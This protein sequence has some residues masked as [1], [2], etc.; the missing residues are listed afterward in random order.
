MRGHYP[1]TCHRFQSAQH[2]T[3]T[4]ELSCREPTLNGNPVGVVCK[5]VSKQRDRIQYCSGRIPIHGI[6]MGPLQQPEVDEERSERNRHQV[7]SGAKRTMSADCMIP[8]LIRRCLPPT[9]NSG[10]PDGL[11]TSFGSQCLNG[12][13]LGVSDHFFFPLPHVPASSRSVAMILLIFSVLFMPGTMVWRS[14]STAC[15]E[16]EDSFHRQEQ[17][18]RDDAQLIYPYLWDSLPTIG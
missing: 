3:D 1:G 6:P 17:F 16:Y 2:N 18:S 14:K 9:G 11:Q 13:Q 10:I 4:Q 12:M 5:L 8:P 7:A 15:I